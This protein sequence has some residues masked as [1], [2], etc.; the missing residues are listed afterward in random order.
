MDAAM[1]DSDRGRFDPFFSENILDLDC[2][3]FVVRI[4]HTM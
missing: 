1:H 3:F 2:A 4:W